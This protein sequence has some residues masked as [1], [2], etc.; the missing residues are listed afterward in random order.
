MTRHL[1]NQQVKNE[2]I[3]LQYIKV[4]GLTVIASF[5]GLECLILKKII[6]QVFFKCLNQ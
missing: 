4:V 6:E 2:E 5:N 1:Y 3:I